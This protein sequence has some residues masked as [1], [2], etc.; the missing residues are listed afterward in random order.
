VISVIVPVHNAA[1]YLP[2]LLR[3]L[4]EQSV[5]GAWEIIAVDNRSTDDSVAVLTAAVRA[6]PIK[7]C[8][9]KRRANP[10][11]ARNIGA[12]SATGDKLLFVD[13]DDAIA[14]GYVDAMADALEQHVF[15]TSRVDSILLNRGHIRDVYG[16]P[17][18][19]DGVDT[20]FNFLPACGVNIGIRREAFEQ[21]GGFPDEFSGS[22]DIAFA[23]R[24]HLAG[25]PVHFVPDAVYHYRHRDSLRRIYGQAVNWGRDNARL[26]AGFRRY[27]MPARSWSLTVK[28]WGGA[29]TDLFVASTALERARAVGRLG[30][31]IGRFKGSLAYRVRYF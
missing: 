31:C 10:S 29:M 16:A 21:L 19:R 9:A 3:S 7:I 18:Q 13:A 14:A 20:Y 22:E 23:W 6:L 15:V 27:G 26:F 4:Q 28:D 17:W 24:A 11:Y 12:A 30:Y 5:C 25:M 1:G 2:E 8:Q